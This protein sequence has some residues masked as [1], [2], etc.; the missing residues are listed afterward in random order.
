MIKKLIDNKAK[1]GGKYERILG[2]LKAVNTIAQF[3]EKHPGKVQLLGINGLLEYTQGDSFSKEEY[4][5]F[6]KGL[7]VIGDA[8]QGCWQERQDIIRAELPPVSEDSEVDG[9][10]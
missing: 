8:M 3:W 7:S 6:V 10:F 2:D 9:S 5:A 4:E 1:E